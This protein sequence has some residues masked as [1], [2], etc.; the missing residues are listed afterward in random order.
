MTFGLDIYVYGFQDI[1]DL[2]DFG[3]KSCVCLVG[4]IEV[5]NDIG[6]N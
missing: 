3:K 1:L 2:S 5:S 4:N 6:H